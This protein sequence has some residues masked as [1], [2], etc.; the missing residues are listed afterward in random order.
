MGNFINIT[1]QDWSAN[2]ADEGLR[3]KFEQLVVYQD[4]RTPETETLKGHAFLVVWVDGLLYRNTPSETFAR[5]VIIDLTNIVELRTTRELGSSYAEYVARNDFE[6]YNAG[7]RNMKWHGTTLNPANNRDLYIGVIEADAT[8]N[9]EEPH[10]LGFEQKSAILVLPTIHPSTFSGTEY[11][12][13]EMFDLLRHRILFHRNVR[14]LE[15][16]GCVRV[17]VARRCR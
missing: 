2:A 15:D 4:E 6:I 12:F 11:C 14:P 8:Y 13:T 5:F 17:G 16:R 9:V 3:R 7:V 1:V 10:T